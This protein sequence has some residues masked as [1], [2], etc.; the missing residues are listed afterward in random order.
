[1]EEWV[2]NKD[3][4]EKL[5]AKEDIT[6]YESEKEFEIKRQL[7]SLKYLDEIRIQQAE[8]KAKEEEIRTQKIIEIPTTL[9]FNIKV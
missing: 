1:M 6:K 2:E 5:S 7:D 3:S 4:L 8:T 9:P